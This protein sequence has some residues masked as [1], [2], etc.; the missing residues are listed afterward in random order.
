MIQIMMPGNNHNVVL[1][2]NNPTA[3]IINA[4]A[5]ILAIGT[6]GAFVFVSLN[7]KYMHGTIIH[8][9]AIVVAVAPPAIPRYGTKSQQS[10][11]VTIDPNIRMYIGILGFPIP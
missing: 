10:A 2:R 9:Q 3:P 7:T 1:G 11:A 5:T 6:F 8:K 4:A